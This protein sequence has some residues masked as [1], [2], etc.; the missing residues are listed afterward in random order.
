V[1]S[2]TTKR[3]RDSTLDYL[4]ADLYPSM[5]SGIYQHF[6]LLSCRVPLIYTAP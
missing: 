3:P 6:A 4:L 1:P 2:G 5:N